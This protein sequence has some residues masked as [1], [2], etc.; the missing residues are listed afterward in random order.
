MNCTQ[1]G[2]VGSRKVVGLLDNIRRRSRRKPQAAGGETESPPGVL[3][4]TFR[5]GRLK[6]AVQS[7][8]TSSPMSLVLVR[9]A[10]QHSRVMA[11][12]V[13]TSSRLSCVPFSAV[14]KANTYSVPKFSIDNLKQTLPIISHVS[15]C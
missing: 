14:R 6:V 3:V 1:S 8:L 2:L 4:S 9:A 5:I 11:A 13:P 15:R 10:T 7:H 12:C